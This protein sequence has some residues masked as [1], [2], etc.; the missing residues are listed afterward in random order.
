MEHSKSSLISHIEFDGFMCVLH[1]VFG[2]LSVSGTVDIESPVSFDGF[3][4]HKYLDKID[5]R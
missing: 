3:T 4:Y 1:I 5:R 2:F